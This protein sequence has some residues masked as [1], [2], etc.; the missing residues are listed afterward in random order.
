MLVYFFKDLYMLALLSP[1][2]ALGEV[3]T[4]TFI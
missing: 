3:E 1:G 2:S 4:K